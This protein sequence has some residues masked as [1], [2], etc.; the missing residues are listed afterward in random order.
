MTAKKKKEF[1]IDE[2][3]DL[4]STDRREIETVNF[5]NQTVRL[6]EFY[7]MPNWLKVICWNSSPSPFQINRNEGDLFDRLNRT[8]RVVPEHE[9]IVRLLAMIAYQDIRIH[10]LEHEINR[11]KGHLLDRMTEVKP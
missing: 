2:S 4:K 10:E 8:S 11:V 6:P 7:Q 3:P 1:W 9:A 5:L